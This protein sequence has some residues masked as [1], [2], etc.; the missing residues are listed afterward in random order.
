MAAGLKTEKKKETDTLLMNKSTI[1]Y[2]PILPAGNINYITCHKLPHG[3]YTKYTKKIK[4]FDSFT[5]RSDHNNKEI[6]CGRIYT[7]KKRAKCPARLKI[8]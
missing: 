3:Q 5:Q 4:L 7:S 6:M 8:Y 2:M 1:S